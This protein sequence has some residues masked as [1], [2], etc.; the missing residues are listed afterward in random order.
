MNIS[1]ILQRTGGILGGGLRL[2]ERIGRRVANDA[3]GVLRQ[4]Q[5]MRPSPKP[6]MDDAT[7]AHK[8]ESEI[9]RGTRIPKSTVNVNVVDGVVWLRGEL[10][11]PEQIRRLEERARAVP[12]VR[13][14][15]NLLHL[16]KTPAPTRADTPK[17]QQ[18]TRSSTRRP[19]PRRTRGRVSADRTDALAPQA[20]A[21][22]AERAK[23]RQ[24]RTPAPLG[25]S[26]EPGGARGQQ[27][28][29]G[30]ATPA[31]PRR[32]SRRPAPAARAA[33]NGVEPATA[34]PQRQIAPAAPLAP[35]APAGSPPD[36]AGPPPP[37]SA[38]SASGSAG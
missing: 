26:G 22:P 37:G 20:E 29:P 27:P 31:P 16:P 15:E 30:R 38:G 8:I 5:H 35:G 19:T 1:Q 18:R 23:R 6:A 14:V 2:T 10:K 36:P 13:G 32:T 12:E 11:R 9:F 4:A 21:P 25:S 28:S 24:G 33:A 34:G 17:R 7:L 3:Y